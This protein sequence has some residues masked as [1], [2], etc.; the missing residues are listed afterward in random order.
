M[1]SLAKLDLVGIQKRQE[2]SRREGPGFGETEQRLKLDEVKTKLN[3]QW[4]KQN[5]L[6]IREVIKN[7]WLPDLSV[8]IWCSTLN[9][10]FF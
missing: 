2:G 8:F 5:S 7:N 6:T 4:V 3:E 9:C 10:L 1:Q